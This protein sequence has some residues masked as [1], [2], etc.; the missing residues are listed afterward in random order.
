MKKLFEKPTIYIPLVFAVA[1]AIGL[2][3]GQLMWLIL[4][5]GASIP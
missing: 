2:L 4:S 3:N 1:F 5:K